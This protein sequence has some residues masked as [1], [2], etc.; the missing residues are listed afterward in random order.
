MK[1]NM[2][3][4]ESLLNMQINST[5][6]EEAKAIISTTRGRIESIRQVYDKLTLHKQYKSMPVEEYI[7][8]LAISI[9]EIFSGKDKISLQTDIADLTMDMKTL[10]P[11]GTIV[12]E[13]LTNSMKYAFRDRDTG[14]IR[15]VLE[16]KDDELSLVIRD[17]GI[18]L[19]SDFDLENPK[20]LGV[21]L[22]KILAGQLGG[23]L[24]MTNDDGTRSEVRF[25]V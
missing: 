10:F 2:N 16:N 9:I 1:N 8:D 12:N 5:L 23:S 22:V 3:S 6:N 19:P 25:P 13:L 18:G 24:V 14:L 21:M 17:N 11:L 20:G 7:E 15:I 4:I